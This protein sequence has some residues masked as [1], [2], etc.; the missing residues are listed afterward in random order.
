[1]SLGLENVHG[2]FAKGVFAFAEGVLVFEEGLD[3]F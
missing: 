3:P 1:V 2:R